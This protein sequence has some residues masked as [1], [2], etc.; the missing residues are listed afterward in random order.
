VSLSNRTVRVAVLPGDGIG[1]EIVPQAVKALNAARGSLSIE[2]G[3]GEIGWTA[4]ESTGA[5]LPQATLDLIDR[6]DA[7]LF[8]AI[9]GP[10]YEAWK[11]KN[12]RGSPLLQLRQ[13]MKLYANYRPI[14]LFPELENASTLKPEVIRGLDLLIIRE[15]NGDIYFGEPRGLVNDAPGARE[16]INTMRYTEPQIRQIAHAAFK[17]AR[18]RRKMVCSVDKANVLETMGLWRDIMTEVGADYPDVTL[19]HLFVDAAAMELLR[20]PTQFDVIVTGNMFG[21]ILSDEAAMLTGSL[22]MLPSASIG[23]NLKGLYEPIHGSAPD[24]AGKDIANPLAAI[25]SAAMLLR[26]SF[27]LEEEARRIENGVR[28]VLAD[29]Y[30]TGDIM[31]PGTKRLGTSAMGDAVAEAISAGV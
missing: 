1:Q 2:L 24:I 3:E 5:A 14:T 4:V 7:I 15:L 28:K 12:P 21:D 6:S 13:D 19:Q 23:A 31:E 22:G 20:R 27:D 16:S 18:R 30:R 10:E 17:A 9:G 11:R 25:L 8:G 26:Y 29:G